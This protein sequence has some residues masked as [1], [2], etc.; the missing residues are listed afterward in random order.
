MNHKEAAMAGYLSAIALAERDKNLQLESLA[1]AHL[2]DY[3]EKSGDAAG[4]AH[5]FQRGLA[6]D[7]KL[8]DPRSEAFDWFNYGQFLAA[9]ALTWNWPMR[10]ICARKFC[11][12]AKAAKISKRWKPPATKW[13][14][15]WG[16]RRSPCRKTCPNCWRARKISQQAPSGSAVSPGF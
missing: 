9:A 11:W 14:C 12:A 7:T 13:K 1:L 2:G 16:K 3:Q 10:A 6:L 4:A 8:E 15:C 5:S